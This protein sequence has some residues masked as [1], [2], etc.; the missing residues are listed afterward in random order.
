MEGGIEEKPRKLVGFLS[1]DR[2][3]TVI[4]PLGGVTYLMYTG[5]RGRSRETWIVNWKWLNEGEEHPL[6]GETYLRR[7]NGRLISYIRREKLPAVHSRRFLVLHPL[8][9]HPRGEQ[10]QKD[11]KMVQEIIG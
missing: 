3:R 7:K 1:G 4:I 8:S 10:V 6:E 2:R 9:A 11:T 5:L